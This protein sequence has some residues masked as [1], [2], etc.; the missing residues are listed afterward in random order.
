MVPADFSRSFGLDGEDEQEVDAEE[1][2]TVAEDEG[3][4]AFNYDDM[5]NLGFYI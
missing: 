2:A 4:S 5:D 1:E 3:D